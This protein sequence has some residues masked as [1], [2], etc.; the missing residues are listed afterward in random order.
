MQTPHGPFT[1]QRVLSNNAVI[2]HTPKGQDVILLGKGMGFGRKS[3]DILSNPKY[4]KIYVVPEGVT[5]QKALAL[6]EQVDPAVINVTQNI[7]ELAKAQLGEGLHPRV[8]VALADH[9]NFTLIRLAQGMEIKNPFLAE[10]E[11]MYPK[12]FSIAKQGAVLILEKMNIF[13]PPEEIGFIALHLHSARHNR[14]V[15]QSLKHAEVINRAVKYIESQF[16]PI[17]EHGGL[18]YTRLLSHLQ[19]CIHRLVNK[20]TIENPFLDKLKQEFSNSYEIARQMSNILEEGLGIPV[21]ED[22]IGYLAMHIERIRRN[23]T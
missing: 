23:K 7:I 9:I 15:S 21:P 22:E 19:S 12:E 13:I 6:M 20:T 3:G 17:K 10:I 16:G 4:E 18:E 14:H 1:I 5:D 8:H 2:A 11:A